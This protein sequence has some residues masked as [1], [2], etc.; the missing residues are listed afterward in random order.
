VV[1][2]KAEDVKAEGVGQFGVADDLGQSPVGTGCPVAGSSWM[3]LR[4]TIPNSMTFLFL[5]PVPLARSVSQ[6][7][8]R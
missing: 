2:T 7:F 5:L 4:E 8:R 6:S 3:S 1:L